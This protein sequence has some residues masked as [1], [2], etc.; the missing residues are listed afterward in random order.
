[1]SRRTD[2]LG[3]F[4]VASIL[5]CT[6]GD[7]PPQRTRIMT[8]EAAGERLSEISNAPVR[9]YSTRD[10]G[11]D[12]NLEARSVVVPAR[13]S[14]QILQRIR[15]E[16]APGIVAFVGTTR[17]LGD[18]QHPGGE[19]IVIADGSSQ[20]DILRVAQSDAVN[21]GMVTEDLIRKL[22]EYDR[23]YGI[24]IFHAETDTIEF[25]LLKLPDDMPGF[26]K[27]L[28][29]FCPDIV[30]QGA[31]TVEALQNEIGKSQQVFLWWD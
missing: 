18:E 11:R 30:D 9:D 24:D 26:C 27:E 19:E 21:Y 3:Y 23:A 12:R 14:R 8:L 25:R 13:R 29:K 15:G 2:V 22:A 16:L 7:T 1:M 10:F 20:F 4:V 31:G 6:S 5:G 17:W 28:Y